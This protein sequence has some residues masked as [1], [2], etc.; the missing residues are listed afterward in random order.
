MKSITR[1]KKYLP[2][3]LVG[4]SVP[5][6]IILGIYLD[7]SRTLIVPIVIVV[8]LIFASMLLWAYANRKTDGSEWWQDDTASGWRGY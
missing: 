1:W 6:I 3:G 5:A 7:L 4:G 8:G 2:L